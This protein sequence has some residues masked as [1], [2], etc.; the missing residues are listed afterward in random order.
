[1]EALF[2]KKC[3]AS[4]EY[5]LLVG[6]VIAGLVVLTVL[7]LNI[8]S[9]NEVGTT[10]TFSSFDKLAIDT[11]IGGDGVKIFSPRQGAPVAKSTGQTFDMNFAI[12]KDATSYTI[13]ARN[14]AGLELC[15]NPVTGKDAPAG[16]LRYR[17]T[18]ACIVDSISPAAGDDYFDVKVLTYKSGAL[19]KEAVEKQ[20]AKKA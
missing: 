20:A 3:Q 5:L 2:G 4:L 10:T 13:Q 11:E 6:G 17:I 19:A 16:D 15:N 18:E 14:I 1:M 8:I 9:A 12:G 7:L